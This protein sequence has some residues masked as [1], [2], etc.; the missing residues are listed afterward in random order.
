MYKKNKKKI[1]KKWK[2]TSS[3]KAQLW[4]VLHIC[5]LQENPSLDVFPKPNH[6]FK[7]DY[8]LECIDPK[9]PSYIC[10][11]TIVKVKG[12]RLRLHFDGWSESY[13]FWTNV[14]SPFIYPM[15]WCE[16]NGQ[17]LHPPRSKSPKVTQFSRSS[18]KNPNIFWFHVVQSKEYEHFNRNFRKIKAL[19]VG[20]SPSKFK[21]S[22]RVVE[23]FKRIKG[24]VDRRELIN[25]VNCLAMVT[26]AWCM[27]NAF[28]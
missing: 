14:D 12:A 1:K 18:S 25:H 20:F 22:I 16:R 28:S 11:C 9:H 27:M 2:Y 10:V 21:S 26:G 3:Y 24:R 6:S 19:G 7:K 4:Q 15:H 8:K 23:K 17:V 5:T 13:D